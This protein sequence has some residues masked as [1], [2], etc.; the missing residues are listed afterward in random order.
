MLLLLCCPPKR[1]RKEKRKIE[2]SRGEETAFARIINT[3]ARHNIAIFTL[4]YVACMRVVV[5]GVCGG[6]LN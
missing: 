3:H 5:L 4:R 1:K 6:S 2:G